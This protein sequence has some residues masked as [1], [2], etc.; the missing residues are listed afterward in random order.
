MPRFVPKQLR[1]VLRSAT[2]RHSLI[3]SGSIF[4]SSG[5]GAVFYLVLAR[6]LGPH[7]YGL[8]SL[9]IAIMG[10]VMTVSDLGLAQSLVK[11]VGAHREN[12]HYF[13]YV[14]LAFR[15]KLIM[16]LA[17]SVVLGL[18]AGVIAQV[19]FHQP[20]LQSLLPLVGL[21]VLFQLLFFLSATIFQGLQKFTHWGT[22]QVGANLIR[23]LLLLPLI[24]F[25]Q[26]SS[27]SSFITFSISYL[28]G[29]IASLFWLDLGW[30]KSKVT[31]EVKR[32]FWDFNRWTAVFV[33]LASITAKL[34]T[35]LTGRFLSLSDVGVYSLAATMVSF[36]PQL[37]SAI[38]AVTTAK[39]A[40]IRDRTHEK[41]YLKKSLVFVTS[42]STAIALL[43]IPTA[44]VVLQLTGAAYSLAMVPFIILLVCSLVFVATNPIRDSILYFHSRPKFF[45][46]LSL[47]QAAT[48]LVGG[49]LAIPMY[50]V[51]GVALAVGFSYL[52]SAAISTGYYLSIHV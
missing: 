42:I 34:D 25:S 39:F 36:L 10:I 18:G 32:E 40:G 47:A 19:V 41:T 6:A 23:L 44:L 3:T 11:F 4:L 52:V 38:G 16:G 48:I 2:V 49:L 45:V 33:I 9:A 31:P 15:T 12:K 7:D 26:I 43:M 46:F 37:A 28:A 24:Y 27:V 8:F 22:L 5:L 30:L 21:S 50:G 20:E 29:F 1:E 14:K 17:S 13:P 35:V 51:T